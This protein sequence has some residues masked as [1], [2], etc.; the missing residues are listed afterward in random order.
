MGVRD[1]AERVVR[2]SWREVQAEDITFM[3]GSIA[4]HAFVSMLPLL[5]F[6]LV[7]LSAVGNDAFTAELVDVTE[8]FLTPYARDLLVESL[9]VTSA[10]TG[11]SLLGAVTLLWGISKIFRSL[12]IAFSKI[13]D[14]QHRTTVLDQVE[15]ALVVLF[16][17]VVA[18]LSFL[19]AGTIFSLFPDLPYLPVLNPLV[20]LAGLGVAFFPIYYVFPDVDVTPREVLPGVIFAALGW[21]ALEAVFQA[22]VSFAGRYEAAYGT[23]GSAF[24]LLIWLYFSGLIL[25]LGAVVNA[26]LAG[27]TGDRNPLD[28]TVARRDR[29]AA[30]RFETNTEVDGGG[31]AT[32]REALE[33]SYREL[34]RAYERLDADGRRLERRVERLE[35]ENDRLERENDRLKRE[36]VDLMRRLAR[37]RQSVWE[38]AKQWVFGE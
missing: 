27:R 11:V 34:G 25:L 14:S 6:L 24:L 29:E 31:A 35:A 21:T 28:E 4:Y 17:L 26:V 2:N 30:E 32:D 1:E 38:R 5:V 16:G 36:N 9:D 22:Y 18:V 13:Y 19:A 15:N 8:Q 33:H 7:V 3:A 37:R 10:R 12:D 23:L 20:L